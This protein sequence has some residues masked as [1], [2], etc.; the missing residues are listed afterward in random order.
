[1]V[2]SLNGP[3]IWDMTTIIHSRLPVDLVP[4]PTE[5]TPSAEAD[6]F[7]GHMQQVHDEAQCH[8]AASKESNKQHVDTRHC[9]V[10]LAEGEMVMVRIQPTRLPPRA[11]NK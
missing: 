1:M 8:I 3:R 7:I 5:A 10:E 11:N 4:L 9:F 2:Q 6:N